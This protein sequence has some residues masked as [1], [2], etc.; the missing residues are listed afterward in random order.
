MLT[1]CLAISLEAC[2]ELVPVA[3]GI[4]WP[5]CLGDRFM[6]KRDQLR[7]R[8]RATERR[9]A[10]RISAAP[11]DQNAVAADE[12]RAQ[13]TDVMELV[14][15]ALLARL[16]NLGATADAIALTALRAVKRGSLPQGA[17]AAALCEQLESIAGR[18]DVTP[19]R[20]RRAIDQLLELA[21]Q[22]SVDGSPQG[23]FMEYLALLAD[24]PCGR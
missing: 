14:V 24:R 4:R 12:D 8:L 7:Q 15:A 20:F 1:G 6:S 23:H 3:Q 5:A 16:G 9:R 21:N 10:A 17:D 11:A 22:A 13:S 2:F 19:I 18:E